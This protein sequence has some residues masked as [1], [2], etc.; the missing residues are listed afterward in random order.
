MLPTFSREEAPSAFATVGIVGSITS[1]Q[2]TDFHR[3][4]GPRLIKK[5]KSAFEALKR[6]EE[7][8]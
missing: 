5:E 8:G 2:A 7:F 1:D 3:V 6:A 4:D